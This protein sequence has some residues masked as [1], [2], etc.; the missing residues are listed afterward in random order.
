MRT[1]WKTL[2]LVYHCDRKAFWTRLFL[3]ALQSVLPL[4]NL[5]VLKELIDSVTTHALSGES[6]GDPAEVGLYVL[7]FCAIFLVNRLVSTWNG[8][9]NDIMSQKLIDY[10][11]DLIQNQS[12]R[13][14]MDFFDNPDFHDTFHRAQQESSFRPIQVLNNFMSLFGSIL[15]IATIVVM[16]A[17]ASWWIILVM[18]LAVIPS[19][20]LRLVKARSIY[21]FR[22]KNTQ[23]YRRT[24]YYSALLTH[25][26]FAKEMRVFG[27]APFFRS[28]FVDI[29][30]QL[31]A[32]LL[33]ISRR[34]ARFDIVC[35]IIETAA[36]MLVLALLL[37]QAFVG[38]LSIGLFVMLF[39]AFRRGQ[40]Y[41]QTLVTSIATL[42][43][44]RLFASNI[45]DFLKLQPLI[46][47]CEHPAPFPSKIETVRFQE[48]SFRYP[49]MDHDV[50]HNFNLSAHVGEICRIEGENG[51]GKTTAIK[52]LMRLHDPQK[53]TILI[54]GIDI[55]QFN[56]EELRR[57]VGV[58]FQ[59][60][61]RFQCTLKENIAFG[62]VKNMDDQQRLQMVASMSGADLA[63]GKMRHGYD[64]LLGRMFD[65]GEE[66]SMGQ[67]Q[68]VAL[69]RQLYSD[70]P[71]LVFD[72][73]TAWLDA[74]SRQ[75][76]YETLQSLQND[77][78]IILIHHI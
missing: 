18:I 40:G 73:P 47:S 19:F 45:F 34:L 74:T 35:A 32:T 28:R 76:F 67:W 14:D 7:C 54:N 27:L 6:A 75:H 55:R 44:N 2:M 38:A 64:T 12:A 9:N 56:I 68:R 60:F 31:V 30:K 52:L 57:S 15:S 66:L 22:R 62:N 69:A 50:L 5:I 53:G 10:M 42:Y 17:A 16:M 61:V 26:D 25:R 37:R 1:L 71:I 65:G 29:R 39:E 70:A 3:V 58:I 63:M 21:G 78:I 41:M 13:L 11:S 49:N 46:R 20:F 36:L 33:H 8:V 43:D 24:S 59:D 23:N 51:Y 48:V 72:E 77:K 4:F